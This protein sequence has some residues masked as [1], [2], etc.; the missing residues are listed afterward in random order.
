MFK[1]VTAM[2]RCAASVESGTENLAVAFAD[3]ALGLQS[4]QFLIKCSNVSDFVE[5]GHVYEG[6]RA[7]DSQTQPSRMQCIVYFA[8]KES[9]GRRE[10]S[11][12]S[13]ST[14]GA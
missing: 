13:R 7:Q 9:H 11:L 12:P 10:M 14:A 3:E 1:F 8:D 5:Y 6:S 4:L 2:S